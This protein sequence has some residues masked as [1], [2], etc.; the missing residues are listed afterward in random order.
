MGVRTIED[1]LT[2]DL[3]A[4]WQQHR[5]EGLPEEW[6]IYHAR[7]DGERRIPCVVIGAEGIERETAKGMEDT[8]RVALR[9]MTVVDMDRETSAEHRA[10]SGALNEALERLDSDALPGCFVHALLLESSEDGVDGRRE[11]KVL[12]RSAVVSRYR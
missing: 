10:V 6:E 4:Y 2:E 1:T 9:V 11:F 12:K 3:V 5:P 7:H 8:G